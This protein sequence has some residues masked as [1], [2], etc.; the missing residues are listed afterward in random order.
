M[1]PSTHPNAL[2][3]CFAGQD[4]E[5]ANVFPDDLK[6]WLNHFEYHAQHPRCVPEGL[7]DKLSREERQLI[8]ASI[9]TFQLGEHSQGTTLLRAAGRFAEAQR[10]PALARITEL[11]IREEQ[12]HAALLAAFMQDHEI[13]LKEAH[14]TER[15]FRAA[16]RGAGLELYLH[17][18]ICAEL[19][20]NVYYRALE[21]ATGCQRL[22]VLCR[23]MVCDELAHIGFESHLLLRLRSRR[24]VLARALLRLTHRGFFMAT[25]AAVWLTHGALLR[26]AGYR[27]RTFLRACMAQFD[28]YLEPASVVLASTVGR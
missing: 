2:P 7:P 18:L 20:G 22:K 12:R 24:G 27:P 6:I 8:G 4:E 28:F 19:I 3:D 16:R 23:T 1:L 11:F 13:P 25:A 26:R 14:W 5:S 15:V 21:A 17:V 10:V 9:A